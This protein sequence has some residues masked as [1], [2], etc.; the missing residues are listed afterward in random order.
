MPAM[1]AQKG[2]MRDN[3]SQRGQFDEG[4]AEKV[5]SSVAADS[6]GMQI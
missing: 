4:M 2:S 6:G 5:R 1:I 3:S